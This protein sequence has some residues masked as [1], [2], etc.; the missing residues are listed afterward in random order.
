MKNRL[1]HTNDKLTLK[2]R[3]VIESVIGILK[4]ICN[5]EHSRH[6]SPANAFVSILA[7]L[8]A[9]SFLGVKPSVKNG[10]SGIR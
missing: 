6:R 10:Y 8:A 1:M 9:Y 5:I 3:G 2:K 7:G 4:N